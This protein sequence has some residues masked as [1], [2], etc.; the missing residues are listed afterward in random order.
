M[1]DPKDKHEFEAPPCDI[2]EL[3]DVKTYKPRYLDRELIIEIRQLR[4]SKKFFSRVQD[5]DNNWSMQ[6][7][8]QETQRRAYNQGK[9]VL[10][11]FCEDI[12][13]E[14]QDSP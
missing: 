13:L 1:I 5:P 7:P 10:D 12:P 9:R 11:F 2:G 3:V 8:P 14:E 4:G 6:Y